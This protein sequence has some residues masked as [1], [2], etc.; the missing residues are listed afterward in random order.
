LLYLFWRWGFPNYLP[1]LASNCYP[2]DFSLPSS[3]DYRNK[4]PAPSCFNFS[5]LMVCYFWQAGLTAIIESTAGQHLLPSPN[6]SHCDTL[7]PQPLQYV[8]FSLV[9]RFPITAVTN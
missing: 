1:K 7:S 3:K 8:D 2:S 4:A 5:D 6:L 9:Y